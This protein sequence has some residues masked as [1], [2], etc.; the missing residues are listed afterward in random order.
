MNS[1]MILSGGFK[2]IN[3]EKCGGCNYKVAGDILVSSEIQFTTSGVNYTIKII[4]NI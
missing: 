3:E 2:G 1:K 4:I